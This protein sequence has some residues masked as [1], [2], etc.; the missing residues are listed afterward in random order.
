SMF[1]G[2]EGKKPSK[3]FDLGNSSH[4]VEA[5]FPFGPQSQ[6]SQ[7]ALGVRS[8]L[9]SIDSFA[10]LRLRRRPTGAK[11]GSLVSVKAETI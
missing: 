7:L 2:V 8:P 4:T 1:P 5:G 10:S 11:F 6:S 3:I 9:V